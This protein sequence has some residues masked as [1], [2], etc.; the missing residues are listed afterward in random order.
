M[1]YYVL[2]V[3]GNGD[4]NDELNVNMIVNEIIMIYNYINSYLMMVAGSI[5]KEKIV[6]NE[7]INRYQN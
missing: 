1:T 6:L 5:K 2:D 3:I 4:Y 7:R